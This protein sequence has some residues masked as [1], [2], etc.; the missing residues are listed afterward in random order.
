M[1]RKIDMKKSFSKF[2]FIQR[3]KSL[4]KKTVLLILVL[5]VAASGTFYET[6]Y[7][8]SRL[9]KVKW[10]PNPKDSFSVKWTYNVTR[11][12]VGSRAPR[13]L[14]EEIIIDMDWLPHNKKEKDDKAPAIGHCRV[15]LKKVKWTYSLAEF[16]IHLDYEEGKEPEVKKVIKVTEEARKAFWVD[17]ADSMVKDMT[18]AVKQELVLDDM[19]GRGIIMKLKKGKDDKAE[20]TVAKSFLFSQRLFLNPRFPEQGVRSGLKFPVSAMCDIPS[21]VSQISQL[22]PVWRVSSARAS[23]VKVSADAKRPINEKSSYEN[24]KGI[25]T[26]SMKVT[27]SPEEGRLISAKRAYTRNIT[28]TRRDLIKKRTLQVKD[29]LQGTEEVTVTR[30]KKKK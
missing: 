9:V 11:K 16:E 6:V 21:Y 28:G 26:L 22:K 8:R 7:S 2:L 23:S 20:T 10:A 4:L 27:F 18:N 5:V 19:L 24:K 25:E 14:K 13:D 1:I 29:Q 15:V 17:K 3:H 30:K 12:D